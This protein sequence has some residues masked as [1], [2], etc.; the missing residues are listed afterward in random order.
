MVD[1]GQSLHI[2]VFYHVLIIFSSVTANFKRLNPNYE[3]PVIKQTNNTANNIP[4]YD[5]YGNQAASPQDPS[6]YH[7]ALPPRYS[8]LKPPPL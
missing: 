5:A 8:D 1:R 3:L 7:I 6:T 2:L 4:V